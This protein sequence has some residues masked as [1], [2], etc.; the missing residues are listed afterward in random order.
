MKLFKYISAV[1]IGMFLIVAC[2]KEV[3]VPVDDSQNY[4]KGEV[5]TIDGEDENSGGITDP[6]NEDED[7]D[8]GKGDGLV[9]DFGEDI[10][11]DDDENITDPNNE[12]EDEDDDR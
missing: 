1:L 4:R 3:I 2:Q 5:N 6:N 9:F 10:D 12:D 8:E 11:L 7:E